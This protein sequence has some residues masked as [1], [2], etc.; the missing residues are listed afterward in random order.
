MTSEDLSRKQETHSANFG[1]GDVD[2]KQ[3]RVGM[4]FLAIDV[5]GIR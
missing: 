2:A 5:A 1:R 4:K 3:I